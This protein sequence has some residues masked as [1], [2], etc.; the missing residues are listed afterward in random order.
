MIQGWRT[1]RYRWD[2]LAELFDVGVATVNRWIGRY[3]KTGTAAALPHGGGQPLQTHDVV[4]ER[5]VV[6]S[7][8]LA[9]G[10]IAEAYS[11]EAGQALER[12]LG[13]ASGSTAGFR[14]T[15]VRP[16]R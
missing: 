13:A 11:K 9:R 15:E 14:A 12:G 16:S 8:D 7:P 2:E 6:A 10:E 4:V 3:R 5:I 1:G